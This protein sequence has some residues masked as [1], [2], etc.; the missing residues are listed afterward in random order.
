MRIKELINEDLGFSHRKSAA[1]STTY[2]FPGMPSSNPYKA[3][4]FAMAM[5]NHKLKDESG[6]AENFAV[7]S[8]YTD[9]DEEIIH[10]AVKLTGEKKIIIADK[11]SHE[12]DSTNR[13]SPV[14]KIKR[15]KYGV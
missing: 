10:D 3:Y 13:V 15:N 2:A 9:G 14:A 5:A 4:R 12:P 1:L 6:P 8:A 7:I 11:G